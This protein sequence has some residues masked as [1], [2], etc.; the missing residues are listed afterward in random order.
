VLIL[1]LNLLLRPAQQYSAQQSVAQALNISTSRLT[2]LARRWTTFREFDI[3]LVDLVTAKGKAKVDELPAETREVV[4]SF[5]RKDDATTSDSSKDKE[6]KT[7]FEPVDVFKTPVRK[8]STSASAQTPSA[9]STSRASTGPVEIR[10]SASAIESKSAME[11]LSEAISTHLVPAGEQFELLCRLRAARALL[12]GSLAED[13]RVKLVTARLLALAIF[14]H[15]H[16]EAQANTALFLYE[17]D[18]TAHVAELLQLDRGVPMPVQT[19]ALAALDALARYRGR[20]TE[21]L[22][23][24][25]AGVAHGILMAMLRH[26]VTEIAATSPTAEGERESESSPPHAFL[27]ALLSFITFLAQNAAGGS[28]LVSAGLVPLLIT[29]V[30][31]RAPARLTVVSKTMQLLDIVLYGFV[32]AFALFVGARGV[33]TLVGRI[34]HEID[35]DIAEGGDTKRA[36]DV[37]LPYGH[38]SVARASV[39]KHSLRSMHRMM[40]SS[41]TSEGLRGLIDSSLLPSIKKIIENRALFGPSILSIGM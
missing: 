13:E 33:D 2:S 19:A 4:F 26:T 22:G 31:N 8:P 15:T 12:S 35:C 40:Q 16:G 23:A 37:A 39:L 29:L 27:D 36:K 21:V 24:V 20:I 5:Y 38:L 11:L 28:M 9:A 18:L 10:L 17:P 14:C 1:A 41:G 25:N 7:G 32:N 34:S 6:E 3:G 30:E